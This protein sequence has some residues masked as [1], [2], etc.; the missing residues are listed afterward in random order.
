MNI[1]HEKGLLHLIW[2]MIFSNLHSRPDFGL[3]NT[4]LTSINNFFD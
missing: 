1:C 2:V 3:G 4:R